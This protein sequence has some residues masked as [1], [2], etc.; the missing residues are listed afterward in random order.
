M[1]DFLKKYSLKE[2]IDKGVK[3]RIRSIVMIA[4]MGSV[5]LLPAAL[6]G[7]MGSEIQKPL[8]IMIV[9]GLLI[10]LVLSFAVLPVVFYYAYR[11]SKLLANNN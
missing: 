5:G 7:G 10:C 2:A 9:G 11:K 8:A 4:L 3:S 1:K 6:S